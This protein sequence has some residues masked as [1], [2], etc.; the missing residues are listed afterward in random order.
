MTWQLQFPGFHRR[1]RGRRHGTRRRLSI[2]HACDIFR[3]LV[4]ATAAEVPICYG[5]AGAAS[6]RSGTSRDLLPGILSTFGFHRPAMGSH[7]ASAH[8]RLMSGGAPGASGSHGTQPR[9]VMIKNRP[10]GALD[11]P[12]VAVHA[13]ILTGDD[14]LPAR[15]RGMPRLPILSGV[16]AGEDGELRSLGWALGAPATEDGGH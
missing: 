9:P 3:V 8:S 7:S 16:L 11:P 14:W 5:K 2:G 10:A 15:R 4:G 6:R 12:G 13:T 1:R